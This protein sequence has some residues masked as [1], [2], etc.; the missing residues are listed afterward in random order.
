MVARG[1]GNGNSKIEKQ[2]REV[3]RY[4]NKPNPVM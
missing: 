3:N 4:K 2:V 1:E